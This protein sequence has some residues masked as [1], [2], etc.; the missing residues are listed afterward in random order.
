MIPKKISPQPISYDK[1]KFDNL[2]DWLNSETSHS[3]FIHDR[4]IHPAYARIVEMGDS[5]LPFIFKSLE[6]EV[7]Q[8]Y[9]AVLTQITGVDPIPSESESMSS[10][11]VRQLWVIWARKN[12]YL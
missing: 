10:D 1:R 3:S 2:V 5:A 7:N 11:S 6:H 8:T 4:L 9:F 12:K